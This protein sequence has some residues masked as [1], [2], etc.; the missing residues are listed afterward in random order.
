MRR[1][2]GICK[3]APGKGSKW[4]V[5]WFGAYDPDSGRKGPEATNVELA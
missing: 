4:R 2:I 1:K 3:S 5:R